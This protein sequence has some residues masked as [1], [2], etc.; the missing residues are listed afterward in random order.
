MAF[1]LAD[2]P[3]IGQQAFALILALIPGVAFQWFGHPQRWKRNTAYASTAVALLVY[4]AV[5]VGIV[6]QEQERRHVTEREQEERKWIGM[7]SEFIHR[8]IRDQ[9]RWAKSKQYELMDKINK[10]KLS[11]AQM[12]TDVRQIDLW[13]GGVDDFF[14]K[15]LP[16]TSAGLSYDFGISGGPFATLNG[17]VGRL[18]SIANGLEDLIHQSR[19]CLPRDARPDESASGKG[20]SR[21]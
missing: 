16:C 12:E 6:L 17:T 15:N 5:S 8:Q 11:S 9:I 4:V 7:R 13:R 3:M 10:Q 2:L 14:D 21:P 20:D 1:E 19:R 18:I